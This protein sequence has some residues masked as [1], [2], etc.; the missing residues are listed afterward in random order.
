MPERPKKRI[1]EDEVQAATL[2]GRLL[3]G[4]VTEEEANDQGAM[5]YSSRTLLG[6]SVPDEGEESEESEEPRER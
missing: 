4:E 2:V 5:T 6:A 3:T 1:P